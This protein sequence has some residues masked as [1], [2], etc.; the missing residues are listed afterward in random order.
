MKSAFTLEKLKPVSQV[1]YLKAAMLVL[2]LVLVG[3]GCVYV[4]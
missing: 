4:S 1:S 3:V 2:V